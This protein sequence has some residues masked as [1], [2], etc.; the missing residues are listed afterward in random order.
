MTFDRDEIRSCM[1]FN[2]VTDSETED[3]LKRHPCKIR[4][5]DKGD[6]VITR[7]ELSENIGV[8]LEGT[9]G[10]YSDSY[11]GGHAMV[12]IGGR[13]YLFGFIAMFYNH[14]HSIT[15]LYSRGCRVA[16]FSVPS[17][18]TPV[19]F[20]STTSPGIISNIFDALT[21]HIRHDF[22]HIYYIGTD[23]VSVKL[24]RYLL[25]QREEQ[26]QNVV[27][28]GMNRTE[29]S[30]F[31]SVYRTSL[32]REIGRMVKENIIEPVGKDKIRILDLQALIDIE[33]TSYK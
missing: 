27:E 17:G 28:L 26:N 13:D 32:S 19:D 14:A 20:I 10:I 2:G 29:L 8:V 30:N 11:Y 6:C 24:T 7:E 5:F 4:R 25:Y 18:Q 21:T 15:S 12:G 33:Q 31:L 9:L 22:D 3:F 16:Y 1:L 23:S